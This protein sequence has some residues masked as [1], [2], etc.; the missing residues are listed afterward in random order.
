[1]SNGAK[2]FSLRSSLLAALITAMAVAT[3][4]DAQT[5]ALTTL[6]PAAGGSETVEVLPPGAP[7]SCP[8]GVQPI[9][10][11][12]LC[13]YHRPGE[14]EALWYDAPAVAAL[15]PGVPIGISV[16]NPNANDNSVF[17][18]ANCEAIR[19]ASCLDPGGSLWPAQAVPINS[20]FTPGPNGL[21]HLQV[22][23]HACPPSAGMAKAVSFTLQPTTGTL[24]EAI[25]WPV[26][27]RAWGNRT[28]LCEMA[29][30]RSDVASS[31]CEVNVP[32]FENSE[33]PHSFS[34]PHTTPIYG[35][36]AGT[37]TIEFAEW[38]PVGSLWPIGSAVHDAE[39]FAPALCC[40]WTPPAPPL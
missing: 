13:S 37:L 36:A 2:D 15:F 38:R 9:F 35:G 34:I 4:A 19:V 18:V 10:G 24:Y 22:L 5:T 16:S 20:C 39:T 17:C 23:S 11:N 40:P 25:A 31:I 3:L 33:T 14:S 1:M 27:T 29:L 8:G 26:A 28:T 6:L 30:E 32:G 21:T 12:V 7:S